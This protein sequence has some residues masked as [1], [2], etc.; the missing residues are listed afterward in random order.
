MGAPVSAV[1]IY[2]L[3]DPRTHELRYV[4]KTNDPSRRLT[5]HLTSARSAIR[6]NHRISWLRSLLAAGVVPVCGVLEI[7]DTTTWVDRERHWIADLRRGGA[8]LLNA[9]D[10]GE[11]VPGRVPTEE[12][13]A[14]MRAQ[15]WRHTPETR[16]LIS[17]KAKARK[18]SDATVARLK[19]MNDARRGTS[20][21]P[22]TCARIAEAKRRTWARWKAET[23]WK[24]FPTM[25]AAACAIAAFNSEGRR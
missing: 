3:Y 9:T 2:G 25:F 8:N 19:A 12:T 11:G 7:C 18:V 17:K 4:G 10:G 16:A 21:A 5:G 22:E 14:K 23:F 20:S 1:V 24:V 15:R 6:P 13:K